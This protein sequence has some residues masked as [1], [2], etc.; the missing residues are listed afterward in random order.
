[1]VVLKTAIVRR[2]IFL[3][4]FVRTQATIPA[5]FQTGPA[6]EAA[7]KRMCAYSTVC[8]E[9]APQLLM[10]HTEC[11]WEIIFATRAHKQ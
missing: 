10:G 2:A 11:I 4:Y 6:Q 5:T 1:M 8:P 3:M 7:A 9:P